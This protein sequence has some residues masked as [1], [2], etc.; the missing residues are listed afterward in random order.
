MGEEAKRQLESGE[1]GNVVQL[2][3]EEAAQT[4]K[5]LKVLFERVN[6]DKILISAELQGGSLIE[7]EVEQ[8]RLRMIASEMYRRRFSRSRFLKGAMFGEPAWDMLLAL[9][10][11]ESTGARYTVTQLSSYAAS[12]ATTALRWIDYLE[13]HHYVVRVPSLEDRRCFFLELS[14]DA[15]TDL[16]AYFREVSRDFDEQGGV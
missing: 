8:R 6:A 9:Y 5:L 12:P 4:A 11:A 15:R 14:D 1:R 16:D 3:P 2:S 7:T 13:S 10:V